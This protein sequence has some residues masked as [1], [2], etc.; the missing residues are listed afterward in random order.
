MHDQTVALSKDFVVCNESDSA[1]ISVRAQ[2][3]ARN[4]SLLIHSM[5]TLDRERVRPWLNWS[6]GPE[7]QHGYTEL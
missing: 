7:T 1:E 2:S 5:T 4:G 6:L 3:L